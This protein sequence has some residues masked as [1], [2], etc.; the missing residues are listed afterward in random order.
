MSM[1]LL[2]QIV[3]DWDLRAKLNDLQR[4]MEVGLRVPLQWVPNTHKGRRP[5][6]IVNIS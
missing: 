5:E 6:V 3:S 2:E 1:Y 4:P